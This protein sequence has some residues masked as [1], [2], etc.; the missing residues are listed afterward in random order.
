MVFNVFK[1][2]FRTLKALMYFMYFQFDLHFVQYY[3]MFPFIFLFGV[4][5]EQNF[6]DYWSADT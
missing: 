1:L 3:F 2:E 4:T 5:K 6:C